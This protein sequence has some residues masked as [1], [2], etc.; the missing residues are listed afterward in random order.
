MT[1]WNAEEIAEF[2]VNN[3]HMDDVRAFSVFDANRGL[4]EDEL[5]H[6]F[7]EDDAGQYVQFCCRQGWCDV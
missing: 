3:E 4:V 2:F 6:R 1:D 7:S 5:F